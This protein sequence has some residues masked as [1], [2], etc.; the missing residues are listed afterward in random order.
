MGCVGF[1]VMPLECQLSG[2]IEG[3]KLRL[4]NEALYREVVGAWPDCAV[5]VTI[6]KKHATRSSQANR[7][8]WGVCVAHVAETTGYTP[9]EVHEIAKQMFLPKHLAVTGKNGELL[10]DYVIGGT[11]ST[12][13]GVEFGEFVAKFKQWALDKLGVLIPEPDSANGDM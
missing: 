2:R 5:T 12:L 1:R 11:T 8:W 4:M 9:E 6:T 10:G 7:Y 3:G 13:N